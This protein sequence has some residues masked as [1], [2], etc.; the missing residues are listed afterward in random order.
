MY[1]YSVETELGFDKALSRVRE[2]LQKEGFGV[3][4]EIDMKTTLK[5]KIDADI[6]D[7]TILGACNPPSAYKSLQAEKEI[8]LM[9]P[10]NVIVYVQ[11]GM[12]H[13]SA[14]LPKTAMGMIENPALMEVAEDIEG[15]LRS[16]IDRME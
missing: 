16:V 9:L 5:K 12:T 3:I 6:E 4:T 15:R 2:E 7:Y 8:G 10:C 1:G 13:V 14:I 11:E